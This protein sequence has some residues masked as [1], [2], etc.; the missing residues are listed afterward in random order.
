MFVRTYF[1]FCVKQN[2]KGKL[3]E[4]IKVGPGIR[5]MKSIKLGPGIRTM[6]SI[7]PCG[8]ANTLQTIYRALI[9]PYFDY[10][11]YLW[12]VCNKQL[13]DK[14]QKFQNQAARIIAGASYEARS[15]DILPSLAWDNLEA[16]R[17]TTKSTLLYK[18]LSNHTGPNLKETLIRRNDMQINYELR[19]VHSDLV[20]PK[21]RR[22]FLKQSFKYGGAKFCVKLYCVN[23]YFEIEN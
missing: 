6:K 12:G 4:L 11:S 9:Q 21:P 19:N 18:V 2:K 20:L 23:R 1:V 15:A 10:C 5:T 13:K 7:K 17:H 16:R 3:K 8:P 14:L 22:E